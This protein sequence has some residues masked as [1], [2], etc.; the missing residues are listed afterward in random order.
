MKLPLSTDGRRRITDGRD[1]FARAIERRFAV[2]LRALAA[3]RIALGLL[4]LADLA[5]RSRNLEAFYT[6]AGVLPRA[7]LYSDYSNGYSL[8]AV[9]GD[10]WTVA[11]LF[12]VAGG[13]A[14]AMLVGYRTR[15]A[16]ACSWLLLV[17]LHVRNPMVL[18]SGDVL[19]R[20]LLFWAIVLP[21]GERWAVD[22]VRTDRD[23]GRGRDR[24]RS[25][26]TVSNVATAALLLQIVGMY[27]SNAAYKAGGE[28]W[29][30]GEAISYVFSLDYQFTFLLG[31][32]LAEQHALLRVL[33]YAW[34]VL[35]ALSPLL[36]L[37]TGL[38][39]AAIASAFAGMHLGMLVT[40]RIDLF[41]LIVVAG[42]L[43]FYPPAVWDRAT[44]LASRLGLAAPLERS[45]VWLASVLPAGPDPGRLVDAVPAPRRVRSTG[46]A[47][48]RALFGTVLPW[49]FLVLVVLSNAQAVGVTEVPD[50]GK[51]VL[52]STKTDQHWRMFAPDP[53]QTDGWYVVPGEL[54]NG[55]EI[56]ALSR[57]EVDRDPPPSHEAVYET[58]RWRKYLS[59]VWS[60]DNTNHRSYLGNYL[61]ER[62]NREHDAQLENLTIYY[63]AQPSEPYNE[64]EP[65]T[66][67]KLQEY[68]CGGEFIQ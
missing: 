18:N 29:L 44:A 10:A 54:E 23:R 27:V 5:R 60:A 46:L 67:V 20:L 62:W 24:D 65:V 52:E 3:F 36:L 37:L 61:C 63:M 19:L 12:V 42:L 56:D 51:E 14:L 25:R 28:L 66:D 31:D 68:E 58:A 4:V 9:A 2:D 30:N 64:T 55:S 41:P 39:R 6:D 45:V 32:V 1:R 40:M 53:L 22:A 57:S 16:T 59:N 13:F 33:T 34:L 38:R 21:L 49:L 50:P 43:P 8:H 48:G 17:S 11:L 47:R 15:L 26:S 7:A 35:V